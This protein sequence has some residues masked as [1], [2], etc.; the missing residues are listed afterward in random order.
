[1]YARVGE[2]PFIVAVRQG[3]LDNI[4]A[5]PVQW[6]ELTIFKFKPEEVHRLN[7]AATGEATLV[8]GANNE[9]TR[10]QGREP[11][12]TVNVQSLLNTLTNLRAVRW[13]GGPTPPQAF[14]QQ[15]IAITFTTSP[16]DKATHKLIVGGSAG[17]GMWHARVEG[18]DGVF[19]MS[20]PDFN[21]LRLPLAP[22]GAP[23]T[24]VPAPDASATP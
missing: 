5:D 20:N 13:I 7:V 21:A 1:V 19:V 10:T 18:R 24:P 4:F 9:W 3:L 15:Q 23:A 22:E 8:R 6:Q 11:I 14:D 12:N 16:D 17:G 2:E